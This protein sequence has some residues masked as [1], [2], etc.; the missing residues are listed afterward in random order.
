MI[1][2]GEFEGRKIAARSQRVKWIAA[3]R[4]DICARLIGRNVTGCRAIK[5]HGQQSAWTTELLVN[6][7]AGQQSAWPAACGANRFA[8]GRFADGRLAQCE[9]RLVD[10]AMRLFKVIDG[11]I[12]R[13]LA[14]AEPRLLL[15]GTV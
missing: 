1:A 7:V 6:R 10:E 5:V 13:S 9:R 14:T 12:M 11:D 3:R 15:A 8:D 4:E 2:I